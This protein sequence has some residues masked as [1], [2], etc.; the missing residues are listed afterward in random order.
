[1]YFVSDWFSILF[2]ISLE[3][4]FANLLCGFVLR[5]KYCFVC[6]KDL[7]LQSISNVYIDPYF[8]SSQK[9]VYGGLRDTIGIGLNARHLRNYV[10]D[11]SIS[12]SAVLSH[13]VHL[14]RAIYA[15]PLFLHYGH[16]I[17]ESLARL[18]AFSNQKKLYPDLKVV[19][20]PFHNNSAELNVDDFPSFVHSIFA[21]LGISMDDIHLV[22]NTLLIEHLLLPEQGCGLNK[23]IHPEFLEYLSSSFAGK[24]ADAEERAM[25]PLG[26]KIYVCRLGVKN[27]GSLL[28]EVLLSHVLEIND[29]EVFYPERFSVV[30]QVLIYQTAECIVFSE[31]T[32]IHSLV[33]CGRLNCPI[34]IIKRRHS[35]TFESQLNSQKIEFTSLGP[36]LLLPEI[37][38][39]GNVNQLHFINPL[40]LVCEISEALNGS[41]IMPTKFS[42]EELIKMDLAHHA[43]LSW[44]QAPQLFKRNFGKLL[45]AVAPLLPFDH[46]QATTN[47]IRFHRKISA[48]ND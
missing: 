47:L 7:S 3:R 23:S 22:K 16:F 24:S 40:Q 20:C 44:N 36:G 39:G 32:A 6:M 27:K 13:E 31:G 8:Y 14:E 5:Y 11:E 25:I 15:G 26:K 21:I 37:Y 34:I 17:M 48:M 19:F 2:A 10:F 42:V 28:G 46:K 45:R 18:W 30:D 9:P 43:I 38:P 4:L 1:M 29:F 33:F 35:S 12:N 41:L